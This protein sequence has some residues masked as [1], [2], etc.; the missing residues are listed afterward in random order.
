MFWSPLGRLIKVADR[1]AANTGADWN[2]VYDGLGRRL[3]VA[4]QAVASGAPSG[5]AVLTTSIYDPQVEF[6]EIGVAV[7]G[8]KAW[9]VFGP[10]LN[11]VFGSFQGTGG[12][13]ATIVDAGGA[14]K[15]VINDFY[16]NVVAT[17]SGGT[18]T[19]FD[20]K[21]SAYGPLSGTA[22]G[23][24]SDVTRVA[25]FSAWRTRR[26]DATGFIYL[27]AR[28]YEPVGGRFLSADPA[29]YAKGMNLYAFCNGDPVNNFD[30]DGRLSKAAWDT[31]PDADIFGLNFG[32]F[33]E[34][35]FEGGIVEGGY[36]VAM[37]FRALPEGLGGLAG[38]ASV[39]PWDTYIGI[40][41]HLDNTLVDGAKLAI[42]TRCAH[43]PGSGFH[44]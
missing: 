15:G 42:N 25:E 28:Y 34:A 44:V 1:D 29:G 10:D 41:E 30:A 27:G 11:G 31:V 26:L 16:G 23:V 14:T 13:E 7:N 32:E 19:W 6:L 21:S 2:A 35:L 20:T 5:G 37:A 4:Q 36:D 40:G 39:H 43:S 8:V 9:K 38:A 24:L 22:T 33:S 17:V 18:T 12:L 3:K